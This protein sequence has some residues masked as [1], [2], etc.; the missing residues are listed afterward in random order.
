MDAF[1]GVIKSGGKTRRAAKLAILNVTHPDILDFIDCKLKEDKKAQA[2][3]AMGYDGTSGPDSEAYS[4]VFYQ[5]ANN[6]VRVTDEF[7]AAVK[8][9]HSYFTLA[10]KDGSPTQEYQARDVMR[11]IA[12]ATWECGDPGIQ[13]DGTINKW[14]T[15]KASGRINASNPC[16]EYMFLDDSACNLASLN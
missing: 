14:H 9:D 2:L 6:S 4:S 10:V 5:N 16:S 12:Q 7:M 3:M 15:S 13:F 8:A 11:K 1:A